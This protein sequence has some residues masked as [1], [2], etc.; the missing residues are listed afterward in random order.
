MPARKCIVYLMAHLVAR[1]VQG[2]PPSGSWCRTLPTAS[3]RL[4]EEGLWR[5]I[6]SL[7]FLSTK[8]GIGCYQERNGGATGLQGNGISSTGHARGKGY[9]GA[10]LRKEQRG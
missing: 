6:P 7:G 1:V 3:L 10:L 4:S 8:V 2:K 5:R 9:G